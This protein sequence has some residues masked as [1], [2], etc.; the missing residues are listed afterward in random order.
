MTH[1]D[2]WY[3]SWFDTEYYH[4]LYQYRDDHE[5]HGFMSKLIDH[6]QPAPGSRVLDLACGRGRHARFLSERHLD[7]TGIDLSENNIQ[8]AKNHQSS[9]L[10]FLRGDMADDLGTSE[11]DFIFNLFTSFGYFKTLA[12]SARAMN[13]IARA[14]KPGGRLVLDFMNVEKVRLGLVKEEELKQGCIHFKVHR[15][16]REGFI[17][18]DIR[19][20]DRDEQ[21][22]FEER[23]QMLNLSAFENMIQDSGMKMLEVFGDFDLRPFRASESERLIMIAERL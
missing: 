21:H 15:F 13:N 11:Y 8:Y 12:Q 20:S 9:K 16:I 14:L 19:I 5:A 18:K 2:T 6:L 7:V 1:H 17:I 23:V 3:K 4:L 10:K 22:N